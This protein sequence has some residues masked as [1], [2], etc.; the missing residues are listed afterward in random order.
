M[1]TVA[2][3]KPLSQKPRRQSIER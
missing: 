2:D 3:A 1:G